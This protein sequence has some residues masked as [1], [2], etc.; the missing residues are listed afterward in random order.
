[1][2]RTR[3]SEDAPPSDEREGR[4][5]PE[6]PQEG[7]TAKVVEDDLTIP[8]HRSLQSEAVRRLVTPWFFAADAVMYTLLGVAFLVGAV[9]MLGYAAVSFVGH[10]QKGDNF[11][12]T[13][14]ALINDLLL[15]MVIMEVLRTI[16]SY[17]EEREVSL[18]PFLFI[19]AIS[20]T[21]R[22]LAIG[23]E[24]SIHSG[25]FT[26]DEFNRRLM[27]LGVNAGVIFAIG[28]VIYLLARGE[29]AT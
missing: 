4:P 16:L 23:A 15:V 8:Q 25:D 9:G 11:A 1:M 13:A 6:A 24:M 21:R 12:E 7:D 17:I 18:R 27:D 28:L 3:T 29:K 5:D 19:G 2:Q 20:A 26:A 10:V 22:I 14:V